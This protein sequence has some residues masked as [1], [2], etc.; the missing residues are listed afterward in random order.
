ML[1][2]MKPAGDRHEN[3]LEQMC[4]TS[5]YPRGSEYMYSPSKSPFIACSAKLSSRLELD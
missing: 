1:E 5:I 2:S 4:L 3:A